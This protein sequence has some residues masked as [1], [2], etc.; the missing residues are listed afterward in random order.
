MLVYTKGAQSDTVVTLNEL[1]TIASPYY[2]F[3]FKHTTLNEI[4]T[5]IA[6][7]ADDTSDYPSRFNLF[8]FNT[9]TLFQNKTLG[10]WSYEVYE[11]TSSTNTDPTGLNKIECG[12]MLLKN[13]SSIT[14]IGHEPTTTFK[15]YAG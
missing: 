14:K 3:V 2:L 7:S 8:Q 12:K 11:Q 13:S 9:I 5:Q 4:V 15:G 10:Q 6:N 1:K